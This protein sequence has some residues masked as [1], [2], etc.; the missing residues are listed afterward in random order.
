MVSPPS[1]PEARLADW[2]L[3]ED[4]TETPFSA[5]GV[6]VTARILVY[7]DDRLRER[8]RERTGVDRLWR[9]FLASRLVLS[10]SSPVTGALRSLVVS[11]ANRG[12]A[13][14]LRDR[15]FTAVDLAERRSL[16]IGDADAR[17]LRYDA[18]CPVDGLTLSV[19]GWLA[20][21]APDRAFRLA[22]GAYPTAVVDD[23]T[24]APGNASDAADTLADSLDPSAFRADLFDL[25]RGTR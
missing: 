24:A 8:L 23:A 2:R 7:A 19:D 18:C 22:G 4:A 21:W 13:D 14:R 25:I 15:G 17:L 10:P 6:T 12:F 1:V 5:A 3:T 16:R 9:F 11:R 20:V